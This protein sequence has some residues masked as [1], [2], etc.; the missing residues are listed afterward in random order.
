[1]RSLLRVLTP[2]VVA[3]LAYECCM[4]ESVALWSRS[5]ATLRV[6]TMAPTSRGW[7]T[8]R[9]DGGSVEART[10][11]MVVSRPRIWFLMFDRLVPRI[12]AT[13][14]GVSIG[15]GGDGVFGGGGVLGGQGVLGDGG[16]WMLFP[17]GGVAVLSP[18]EASLLAKWGN[19]DSGGGPPGGNHTATRH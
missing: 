6:T 9:V 12:V 5:A 18:R 14:G 7:A 15:I 16:S 1:M 4:N 2:A 8:V 17:Y 19:P 13:S 3:V 10:I 11:R